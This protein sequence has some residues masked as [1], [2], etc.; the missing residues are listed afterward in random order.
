MDLSDPPSGYQGVINFPTT[1]GFLLGR[2]LLRNN[3][4]DLDIVHSY[5]AGTQVSLV[6]RSNSVGPAPPP[7]TLDLLT[8]SL[9]GSA[10]EQLL[11]LTARLSQYDPPEVLDENSNVTAILALAGINNGTYTQPPAVNLTAAVEGVELGLYQDLTNPA[12][13]QGFGNGWQQFISEL[14]G[15]FNSDFAARTYIAETGYAQLVASVTL[16]PAYVGED[17]GAS[18]FVGP[19]AA[20]LFTFSAKPKVKGFWSLT[21]Y[22]ENQY[23]IPNGLE[24]YALGD[25]SNLTYPDGSL[26]YGDSDHADDEFQIL[27]QPADV[28]PPSNWTSK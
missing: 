20:T 24:V 18:L 10:P 3:S 25:R 23:L 22:G 14:S 15:N 26:L 27:I 1:Y 19:C 17:S 6:N 7:L 28:T 4:T 16:Y 11:Q 9:T 2:I 5:Q 21:A 8:D 13:V 12:H